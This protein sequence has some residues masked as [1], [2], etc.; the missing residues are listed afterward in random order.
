MYNVATQGLSVVY[1]NSHFVLID[2]AGLNV[3]LLRKS[4]LDT[5]MKLVRDKQ[6]TELFFKICYYSDKL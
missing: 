6:L 4:Y 5:N 3:F 2:T 1:D